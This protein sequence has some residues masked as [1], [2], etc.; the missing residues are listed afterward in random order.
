M[1]A[2]TRG[3]GKGRLAQALD[4]VRL[5]VSS[6][7][8]SPFEYWSFGLFDDT[9]YPWREKRRFVGRRSRVYRR[10]RDRRWYA[11]ADDKL[12][13]HAFLAGM[14]V[15]TPALYAVFS[16]DGRRVGDQPTFTDAKALAAHLRDGMPYPFFGKPVQGTYGAGAI[17]ATGYDRAHDRLVTLHGGA[18]SVEDFVTGLVDPRG[19]GYLFQAAVEPHP[20][21]AALC[22]P[23]LPS[24]RFDIFWGDRAPRVVFAKVMIPTGTN[25]VNNFRSGRLGN[26]YA[27]ADERGVLGPVVRRFTWDHVETSAR[28]PDTGAQLDGVILP[29]WETLRDFALALAPLVPGFRLQSWDVA[30]TVHGPIALEL[31]RGTDSVFLGQR[32]TGRGFLDDEIGACVRTR[33]V[34]A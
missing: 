29:H 32:L 34:L 13:L 20:D 10:L 31:N 27:I 18:V 9:R 1:N 23:R 8:L 21:H 26:L 22:G 16:R 15:P 19:M 11:L 3:G 17:F 25:V 5:T 33:P 4:L 14:G 12:V 28:H 6:S 24:A 2:V 30:M 7:R